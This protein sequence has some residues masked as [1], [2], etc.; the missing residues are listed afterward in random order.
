[1][2]IFF[3]ELEAQKNQ[4]YKLTIF[5]CPHLKHRKVGGQKK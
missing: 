1:M 3:K 4:V 5:I 2:M